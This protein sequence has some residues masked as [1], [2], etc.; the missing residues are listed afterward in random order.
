MLPYNNLYYALVSKCVKFFIRMVISVWR[1][2]SLFS[3]LVVTL[4]CI[5]W[6]LRLYDVGCEKR[7]KGKEEK[8]KRNHHF[9]TTSFLLWNYPTKIDKKRNRMQYTLHFLIYWIGHT[10]TLFCNKKSGKVLES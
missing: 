7:R 1:K 4:K 9:F 8:R 2:R 6:F 3:D 10:S 5:A